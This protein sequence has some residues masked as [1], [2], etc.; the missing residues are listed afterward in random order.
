MKVKI[1][2]VQEEMEETSIFDLLKQRNIEPRMVSVELNSEIID[3]EELP[4][5]KLREGDELEFLY[6][7][8]GGRI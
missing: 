1:N 2:G 6:F 3:K 7:M 5:V 8:G 4:N